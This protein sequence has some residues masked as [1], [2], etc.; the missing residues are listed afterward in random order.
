MTPL[1][2][3]AILSILCLLNLPFGAF[4]QLPMPTYGWNLGNTL[5]PPCGEGCWGPAA[6][7]ALINTVAHAGFNTIRIPCAWNSHANQTTYVIDPVF[8]ARVQQVV[9]WCLATNLTVVI[10]DHWDGGWLETNL[11]GTVNSTINAKMNSYWSQIASAFAGYSNNVLFAAANEPNCDNAAKMAELMTYYNT[12]VVAV[13]GAGGYNTNRW[14]V[15]QGPNTDID[16]TYNLMN[17]LP[18]DSTPG[19]LMVEVHYYT[20]WNLCG[21][22]SDQSWGNMFY[23]WGAAYHSTSNP[24]R[25]ATYG[26]EAYLD[27]Q[28]QKMTDKFVSHGIPVMIGDVRRDEAHDSAGTRPEPASRVADVLPQIHCRFGA[29]PRAESVLLGYTGDRTGLQLDQR[30]RL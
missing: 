2:R 20:P 11:T 6:T 19:R 27:A 24:T 5:E 3:S 29:Q 18:S 22:S 4:A 15:V 17:S 8:M 9:N 23:F 10:N 7:Q 1:I 26:E 13:R 25:N 16:T 28:F 12:F 21:L 30:R 14:L